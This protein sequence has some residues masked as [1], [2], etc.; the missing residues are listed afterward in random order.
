MVVHEGEVMMPE[1]IYF[2][3]ANKKIDAK[4]KEF[5]ASKEKCRRREML[6]AIENIQVDN[7]NNIRC[8]NVCNGLD[9]ISPSLRFETVTN[10]SAVIQ[11]KRRRTRKISKQLSDLRLHC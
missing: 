10:Q 8:C 2:T 3:V 6:K 9:C 7:T 4:V 1:H 11:R 5:C